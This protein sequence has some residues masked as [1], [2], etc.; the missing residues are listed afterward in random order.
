LNH[1]HIPDQLGQSDRHAFEGITFAHY[2]ALGEVGGDV[3]MCFF[4]SD[5]NFPALKDLLSSGHHG[6]RD[7]TTSNY[8]IAIKLNSLS[9]PGLVYIINLK[10]PDLA[11]L[12]HVYMF[13]YQLT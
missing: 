3:G 4:D 9:D 11:L 8:H 7:P 5:L 13:I 12:I 6:R 10:F 2:A 1:Q